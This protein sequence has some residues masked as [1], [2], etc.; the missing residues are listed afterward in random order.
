MAVGVAASCGTSQPESKREPEAGIIT[1]IF[2]SAA[3]SAT[4]ARIEELRRRFQVWPAATRPL[5]RP[6]PPPLAEPS[7]VIGASAVS[8]FERTPTG[9]R[10]VLAKAAHRAAHAEAKVELPLFAHAPVRLEAPASEVALAFTLEGAVDAPLEVADGIARYAQAWNGSDVIHRVDASGTEDFV[11]VDQAPPAEELRYLVDVSRVP[12][13][14][15]VSNAL[16]FLDEEGAPRLR[17]APPS[18][19][20]ALGA[21]HEARLAVDGCAFDTNPAGPWGRRVT[22]PGAASCAVRVTWHDVSYPILVDPAWKATNGLMV[23]SR[24]YNT[25]T[26]LGNGKVLVAG[27][28]PNGTNGTGELYD[29]TTGTFAASGT[30]AEQ[31][32]RHTANLLGSG[33]VLVAGGGYPNYN[34]CELY[35]PSTGTFSPTGAMATAW[36]YGHAATLIN[37]DV[38]LVTGGYLSGTGSLATAE[39]YVDSAG[40]WGGA[41]SMTIGRSGHV[42]VLL[43]SGKVLLAGG[44]F[45][46]SA[47]LWDPVNATFT[48]TGSM[49]AT[50]V[51][52]AASLLPSGKVLVAGGG[53]A[54]GSQSSAELYDPAT[55]QFTLTGSMA[56]GR[57]LFTM[58]ALTTNEVLVAGGSSDPSSSTPTAF[59]S[60]EIYVPASASFISAGSMLTARYGFDATALSSGQ[61]L[62]MGGRSTP[63]AAWGTNTAEL[64]GRLA[65]GAACSG[66]GECLSEAC[67][68]GICC[69]AACNPATCTQ[70]TAGTGACAPVTNADDPYTCTGTQ[71]CDAT[72]A[73]KLKPGQPCPGGATMCA[74]GFCVNGVCCGTACATPCAVCAAALGAPADGTCGPS[75]AHAAGTPSCAPFLCDG[76]T[77]TCPTTCASDTDCAANAYCAANA[78]CQAGKAQGA[79]CNQ[80]ASADCKVAGCHD[81]AS[82]FC[83]DGVCCDSACTAATGHFCQ[84]CSAALKQSGADG[85]CGPAK[86]NT[87][88]HADTCAVDPNYPGDCGAPGTCDGTG[89]CRKTAAQG[90]FCGGNMMPTCANGTVTG[91][92]CNA[93][94]VCAGTSASCGLYAC[95]AT[96]TKC[97]T[98]CATDGDC[99]LSASAY[100]DTGTGTCKVKQPN[101]ATCASG[102]ACNSG[103]CFDSVCCNVACGGICEACNTAQNKGAC[104]PLTGDP[105]MV[106]HP[107]CPGDGSSCAGKCDGADTTMCHFAGAGTPCGK[108][109]SCNGDVSTAAQACDG[110]GTCAPATTKNCTPY[111][112]D[113]TSGACKQTCTSTA[114]CA[115][116]AVC[117]TGTG[118]CAAATATCSDPFTAMAPDGTLTSCEPYRCKNGTCATSCMVDADCAGTDTCV[119]GAC[120]AASNASGSSGSSGAGGGGAGMPGAKGGCGCR[121]VSDAPPGASVLFL[122][123]ALTVARSRR[124]GAK[125]AGIASS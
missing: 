116:G 99:S 77:T 9:A 46:P 5:G 63:S 69:A 125:S 32:Q 78:T 97:N 54:T 35:D 60:A 59:A 41:N 92:F 15:L 24:W 37:A 45:G 82:G 51:F 52:A 43:P 36:Q 34:A 115:Q 73:C 83:V 44:P 114:D 29:P 22:P 90:T 86:D 23:V 76:V 68:D 56:T 11:V 39:L 18:V 42:G 26:L 53:G 84:A 61:V 58:T 80:A 118:K 13:L 120:V 17:V 19:V 124:R 64:F 30:M 121:T 81:C 57:A 95:D 12:G 8:S 40:F 48:A 27:G 122:A 67:N 28:D 117:D 70:C 98:S 7:P 62:V 74:S 72:G 107:A 88:P 119:K 100:C 113:A 79:A 20:D 55:G 33:K 123:A 71:T 14:R 65:P 101:G 4:Q 85:T 50:R 3:A 94:G 111:A 103:Y 93:G 21:A 75:L 47:E 108:A 109:A 89:M 112:C 91:L 38:V 96:N 87:N 66:D 105:T 106:G 16:E 2:P 104:V 1:S 10:P 6:A 102:T 49:T 25:A 31:R 110:S